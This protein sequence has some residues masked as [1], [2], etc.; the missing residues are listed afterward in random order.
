MA[1]TAP[2]RVA[3]ADDSGLMRALVGRALEDAGFTVVGRA[4]DGAEALALLRDVRPD[5]LTLDLTMPGMGGLEVLRRMAAGEAPA[6]PVVVVSA[7]SPSEGATAIAALTA[8]AFELVAKPAA[9]E[10]LAFTAELEAKVRAAAERSRANRAV[11]RER[12]SVV[13]PPAPRPPVPAARPARPAR[14]GRAKV[15]VIA[16]STGG[17]RALSVLLPELPAPLGRGAIVVQHM[18]AGFTRSLAE[19][20]DR[21]SALNVREAVDGDRLEP[22]AV[23][24]A[25][26]GLHLRVDEGGGVR[27]TLEPPVG[28]LRPRADHTIAD[29]ARCFGERVLLVVLTGMGRD[30]T[31]GAR[32]VRRLGGRILVESAE[33]STVYGMPRSVAEAGLAD[34]ILPLPELAGA[35]AEHAGGPA[36]ARSAT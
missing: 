17:P 4:R 23:L 29:I 3:L 28:G 15:V 26:G 1:S 13:R 12:P 31:D 6:V 36:V 16:S 20:L 19:R 30:A 7:F 24:V 11:A 32:E 27:T 25:P 9:G 10:L 18:P 2:I 35:I 34:A 21:S 14:A 5:V 33:T 22:G 8:G